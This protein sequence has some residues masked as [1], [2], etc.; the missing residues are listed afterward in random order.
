MSSLLLTQNKRSYFGVTKRKV[1]RGGRVRGNGRGVITRRVAAEHLRL[2][3]GMYGRCKVTETERGKSE[4][5]NGYT[6][7]TVRCL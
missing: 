2:G 6:K 7:V 3:L 5:R 1:M 4:R